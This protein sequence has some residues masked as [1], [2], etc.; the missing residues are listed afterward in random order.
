MMVVAFSLQTLILS[1]DVKGDRHYTIYKAVVNT[2]LGIM[3]QRI[4]NL[5]K[6]EG[7]YKKREQGKWTLNNTGKKLL[8]F[9]DVGTSIY[10]KIALCT[11]EVDSIQDR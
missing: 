9:K 3:A 1:C 6:R 11:I 7:Q 8:R 10:S 5:F 2:N 4:S